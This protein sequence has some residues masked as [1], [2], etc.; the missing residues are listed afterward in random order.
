LAIV[1]HVALSTML[2]LLPRPLLVKTRPG[3]VAIAP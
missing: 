3:V 1:F 2:A